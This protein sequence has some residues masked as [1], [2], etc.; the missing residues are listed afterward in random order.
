MKRIFV[1]G[2][3]YRP[4]DKTTEEIIL[5]GELILAS[6]RLFDIFKGY[7]IFEKVKDRILIINNVD[8]TIETIRARLNSV[9]THIILLASGDP[10]FFGIGRRVLGEFGYDTVDIIPDL[11]SLQVASSRIKIPWDDAF[12]LSLHG[13]PDPLKKRHLPYILDDIPS[14]LIRYRKLAI[15]TDSVNN[16]SRIAETLECFSKD[17]DPVTIHV[18]ERL[19]YDDERIIIGTPDEIKNISFREPNIVI[20]ILKDHTVETS[21]VF[22]LTENE[23]EHTRG[24]ITKDEVRAVTV[25]K[26]RL[27]S[28]GVVWDVGAGSGSVSLEI[29]GISPSLKV[30]AIEKDACEINNLKTNIKRLRRWNV[31][32]VEGEAPHVFGGLEKPGRVFIG[33]SG[34]RLEEIILQISGIMAEGVIVINATILE[35]MNTAVKILKESDFDVDLTVLNVSRMKSLISG[36]HLSSLNPVF[37]IRGIRD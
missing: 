10:M 36:S 8:E 4:F 5:E 37:I 1:I 25:H 18:C 11:S 33:G 34:G 32:P 23:I 35:N 16:P 14:L 20:V 24:L 17:E 13:G 27:P 12:F 26:L 22:G 29:A 19:G 9:K 31:I 30:Y 28:K 21:P 7:D 2:T 6:R 3:G 15:L